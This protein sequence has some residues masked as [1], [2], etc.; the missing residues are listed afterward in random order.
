M[1][2]QQLRTAAANKLF[3]GHEQAK[4][5]R[6]IL[7]RSLSDSRSIP[8]IYVRFQVGRTY[9]GSGLSSATPFGRSASVSPLLIGWDVEGTCSAL[10]NSNC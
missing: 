3:R 9:T 1:P 8:H 2:L 6:T 4:L 7:S 5:P 10:V